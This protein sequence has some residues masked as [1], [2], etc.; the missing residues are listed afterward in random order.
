LDVP[1]GWNHEK[2]S[3]G[4]TTPQPLKPGDLSTVQF[5]IT[6]PESARYT[7]PYFTR[8]DPEAETVYRINDP[9]LNTHPWP[10]YP[11]RA[12]ATFS[13]G[14]GSSEA[15]AI[16]KIRFVD[17]ALGQSERPLAVGPPISVLLNTPVLVVPV[18]DRAHSELEVSVRSN[19]ET[20]VHATLHLETPPGWK[21]EPQSLPVDLDHDGDLNSYTFHIAM[22]GLREGRYEVKA[23]ADYNGKQY[24]EGFKIIS[25]PDLDSFY[26]YRSAV[27]T[28][29][30]V[31]VKLPQHLKIGY[32]MGA[33]DEIPAVM[34]TL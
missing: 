21:V 3:P 17:P 33:G 9:K 26:A 24:S 19:T 29:Q 7:R 8:G 27:Q 18:G 13:V 1:E 6:V 23:R 22:Q 2:V 4:S 16:A 14:A 15:G 5:K 12:V 11:V 30:A 10:P 31:D 34:E 25:R 28:V 20:P 32:V